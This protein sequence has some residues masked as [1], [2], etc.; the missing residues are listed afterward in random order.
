MMTLRKPGEASE[1]KRLPNSTLIGRFLSSA[2]LR[3]AV[4]TGLSSF[5]LT[6][7]IGYF[8]H[9]LRF[10]NNEDVINAHLFWLK[11][12]SGPLALS[13]LVGVLSSRARHC[14]NISTLQTIITVAV[15]PFAAFCIF[16]VTYFIVSAFYYG[17]NTPAVVF[18]IFLLAF[19]AVA[20]VAR[21]SVH[22]CCN[23][24]KPSRVKG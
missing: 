5:V 14:Q 8:I 17:P 19:S 23:L 24:N 16:I 22:F 1:G 4:F 12:V 11:Y 9:K 3:L 6:L 15:T 2:V 13:T 20:I 18:V 7:A 10:S 21:W